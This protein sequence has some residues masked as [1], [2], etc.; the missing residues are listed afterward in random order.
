MQT[1]SQP[2]GVERGVRRLVR[3]ALAGLLAGSMAWSAGA[4]SVRLLGDV[5]LRDDRRA[6]APVVLALSQGQAV[7]L[8]QLRGGWAQV[9]AG[10][11]QGWLRA[12]QLDLAAPETAA[13]AQLETGRRA[14]GATALTLGVRTLPPRSTRHALIVGIG[15]Y[16]ADPAR[17][18]ADLAGVPHDMR[19]ALAMAAQMQ[20]PAENVTLLRDAQATRAGVQQALQELQARVQPG[21]RV[22]LYWSG[23]GSR[24]F[25]P[26]EGG[27]VEAL[28]PHDLQ[29]IGNRQFAQWLQP[30][31]D[32]TDKLM[33]VYDACHSG[34]I[35]SAAGA[36]AR[37]WPGGWTPKFTPGA[38]ACA[39]PVNLRTRSLDSAV[40]S[41]GVSGQD[42]VH[43]M[44]SRPDEVSFDHAD[45]GGLAT[46]SLLACMSGAAVDADA[47][48]AVSIDEI[49]AC[50]QARIDRALRGQAQID[51]HHLV[52][53]GNRGFVP[54]WFAAAPGV[55]GASA[56]VAAAPAVAA[57]AAPAAPAASPVVAAPVQTVLEQIHAQRDSKRRVEVRAV[58]ERLRIGADT[59]DFSVTSS[60]PGHLYVAM[61]G[62]DRQSLVLLFPNELDGRNRIAA[63]ESVLL[64]R[65][66]W[67]V[68]AGGPP[69]EDTLLVMVT[70]GPR[71]L[72]GLGGGRA[73][74]FAKPLTDAAGRARLQWLLGSNAG[75][76]S[77]QGSG[78]SDAFG[79]ALLRVQ[80]Y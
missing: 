52:I 41:L 51:P 15:R 49:A 53:T 6:D 10:G 71:D 73:G 28:V 13:V 34:G 43:L 59:L 61:L 65:P 20:I 60:H 68:A 35:G 27:C 16:R 50:A 17:P 75:G 22:F 80:E 23:H 54:A 40:R 78:C 57:P 55:P 37:S 3:G 9:Q 70:D 77:C 2:G 29:D 18:V 32:K 33:V 69:G 1:E 12:S 4:Q 19:S 21:D 46:S 44:S 58:A 76:G 42:V 62:S 5:P 25:D 8:L 67:R 31:A 64:P 26:Q 30:L 79:S 36:P 47:S 66:G 14:P 39:Q 11:R 48:G 63:G 74:P 72:S 56:A 38:Q 24:Y 45:S 7:E